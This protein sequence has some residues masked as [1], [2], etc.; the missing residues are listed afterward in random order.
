MITPRTGW[1]MSR[2][3]GMAAWSP[4]FPA[5]RWSYHPAMHVALLAN[6]AWLDEE[7]ALFRHLVVGLIDEQVR[8]SQVVPDAVGVDELSV[9]GEQVFWQESR[10]AAVNWRRLHR[11]APQLGALHVDMIHVL[12]GALWWPGLMLGQAVGAS[13]LLQ[14]NA[15]ADLG[16]I[17]WLQRLPRRVAGGPISFAATTG[18]LAEATEQRVEGWAPVYTLPPGVHAQT[19]AGGTATEQP[20]AAVVSGDGRLDGDYQALLTGMADFLET[21]PQAQFFFD[22]QGSTQQ[23]LWRE[24]ERLELL[25][26]MS[27]IPRR[28]GHREMLLRADVLLQPQ[29]LGR[30]RSLTLQAMAHG[31]PIVARQDPWLDYLIDDTT[32]W[33][34]DHPTPSAWRTMLHRL[35]EAPGRAQALGQSA[36][37]WVSQHR[38]A[39]DQI[40]RALSAYR[41]LTGAAIPFSA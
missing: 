21:H 25:S 22:G 26:N 15:A 5:K 12:D 11:L 38:L 4:V 39:A 27:F 16:R 6:T 20:L 41:S 1:G 14:V 17:D 31:R 18:P 36:H 24:A 32:A 7:L 9:F 28:L 10:L 2:M 23:K 33:I 40:A 35:V 13:V 34:I 29:A 3:A 37:Q 19:G 8:V 30:S